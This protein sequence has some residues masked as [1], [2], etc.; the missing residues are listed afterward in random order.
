MEQE[1]AEK[2]KAEDE[3]RAKQAKLASLE[4]VFEVK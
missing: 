4:P 2:K 1:A 3:A